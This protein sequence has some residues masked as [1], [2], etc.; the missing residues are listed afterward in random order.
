[1]IPATKWG[2]ELLKNRSK[3]DKHLQRFEQG[4][5]YYSLLVNQV[6]KDYIVL[7]F[8]TPIPTKSRPSRC[9]PL[10]CLCVCVDMICFTII[11]HSHNL[12][13][14]LLVNNFRGITIVDSGELNI[15][16]SFALSEN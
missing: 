1:M 2:V 3:I 7:G 8:T 6:I 10:F 15:V 12:Y 11:D 9:F 13:H 5:Q 14:V 4:G 16:D